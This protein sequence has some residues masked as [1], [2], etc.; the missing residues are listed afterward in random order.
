MSRTCLS[1]VA[2]LS[3]GAL[4]LHA[5]GWI[6]PGIGRPTGF[7]VVKTRSN[8]TVRVVG[9]VA[10]VEVEE[11]FENRGAGM[12]EGEYLYPLPGEAVFGNFS[13]F[14]GDRE[15]RG[16]TMNAD[17]AR[18]IYEG[19]VRRKRDPALIEL[20][21]HGLLRARVFPIN[22]GETRKITLR[23]TQVLSRS[24]DALEFKYAAGGRATNR[25][26]EGTM[27]PVAANERVPL[28]FTLSADTSA[29]FGDPFSP[30]HR[31]TV[32]R[33]QGR[34]TVRPADQLDGDFALFLPLTRNLVGMTLVTHRPVGELGYFMLTLS[35]SR[36]TGRGVPRDI[37][38]VVDVSG[39]MSGE[40]LDQAKAALHQLLRSLSPTDRFRLIAFSSGV[41]PYNDAFTTA[42]P[43]SVAA[44]DHWVDG[45]IADGGT[46]IFAALT[47]A[48]RVTGNPE[49]LPVV[50]FVTDGLPSVGEQ[51][52]ERIASQ[53]E[54]V[55]GDAR[56]FAFGVGYDV[57]TYLLDR[58][59]AVGRGATQYV[60]AGES[61]ADKLGSLV[62]KIQNPVLVD[63][64]LGDSPVTLSE[65]YPGQLPDLFSGD[66]L[67]IF[68]RY[69]ASSDRSGTLAVTGRRN[70]QAER[71]TVA[72]SFPAH[73]DGND[74]IERLWA[75]RKLGVLTRQARLNGNN[76]ELIGEIRRTALRYG[77]LSEYTSYLVQEPEFANAGGAMRI[78]R[79]PASPVM[80]QAS[81]QGASGQGAVAKA[82]GDRLMREARTSADIM[83]LDSTRV[84]N[85]IATSAGVGSSATVPVRA[86][87]GRG[88]ALRNGIWTDRS[89]SD[90]VHVVTVEP[91]GDAYF[92]LLKA[93]PELKPYWTAFEQVLVQGR[94]ISIVVHAHGA[95]TL[96]DARITEVVTAFRGH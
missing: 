38:A 24:G 89:Q 65:I 17:S 62:A 7:G 45:L 43:D 85:V 58:I 47:E 73:A 44:A 27:H 28:T 84:R 34:L 87:A 23:Y 54:R 75:S 20:A 5:Q 22:P 50:L 55:R 80:D 29:A 33:D 94:G 36:T 21:G 12:G 41:R 13:L 59:S 53:V 82:E 69:D 10:T 46:D 48:F 52:P 79:A 8:V 61:V 19:I 77:L 88:F 26:S 6:E 95:A 96:S 83:R 76:P 25:M 40:K 74:Y 68:G 57:N 86:V 60:Q 93:L 35:P 71:L 4:P 18:T 78:L 42:L 15:L 64:A 91:Y 63:L 16:E 31:L 9:R 72:A 32:T 1:L 66:E 14:Q 70:G 92:R 67:V 56:V 39:S 51:N 81:L 2:A 90:T 49:R 37:T 3:L 30:T 11:W